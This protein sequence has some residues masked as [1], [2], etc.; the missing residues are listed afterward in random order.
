M[1]AETNG[2]NVNPF[3]ASINPPSRLF[4]SV[5]ALVIRTSG[6]RAIGYGILYQGAVDGR[7]Y[8]GNAVASAKAVRVEPIQGGII[9]CGG[10]LR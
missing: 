8:L 9:M 10:N 1:P 6:C 3:E 5:M 4:D 2:I 7:E